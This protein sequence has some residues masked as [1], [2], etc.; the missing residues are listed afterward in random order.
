MFNSRTMYNRTILQNEKTL[1]KKYTMNHLLKRERIKFSLDDSNKK[2]AFPQSCL[3]WTEI[4][5]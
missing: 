3:R 2:Y 4:S 5:S 1:S